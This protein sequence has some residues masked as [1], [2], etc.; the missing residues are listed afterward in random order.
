[1]C[2]PKNAVEL[3]R[4]QWYYAVALIQLNN[5]EAVSRRLFNRVKM[6]LGIS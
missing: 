6:Q 3:E 1:M 5:S 2:V 4:L